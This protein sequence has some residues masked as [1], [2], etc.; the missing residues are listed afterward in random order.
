LSVD[1][2][3]YP[4]VHQ[5]LETVG[6]IWAHPHATAKGGVLGEALTQRPVHPPPGSLG[7]ELEALATNPP[8]LT[9][10]LPEVHFNATMLAIYD[11]HYGHGG[12]AAYLEW[13]YDRNRRL[14]TKPAYKMLFL[15]ISPE[16]LMRGLGARW[17]AFRKGSTLT[18]T[19]HQAKGAEVRL[20]HARHLHPEQSLR[21]FAQ[22]W[23]AAVECAGGKKVESELVHTEPNEARYSIRWT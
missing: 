21:A 14:F 3:R 23:K 15:V 7:P 5:Y 20:A 10:W 13:V 9:G 12:M 1:I 4:S 2:V 18:A 16:R 6:G 22:A 8:L 19:T 11:E 17:A